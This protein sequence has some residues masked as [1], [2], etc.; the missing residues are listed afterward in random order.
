MDDHFHGRTAGAKTPVLGCECRHRYDEA[1]ATLDAAVE[2]A[3]VGFGD[4]DRRGN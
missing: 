1:V 3:R 4:N 2:A